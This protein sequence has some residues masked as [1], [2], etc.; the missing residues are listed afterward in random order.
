MM[1]TMNATHDLRTD[2]SHPSRPTA[3]ELD[4][5][6]TQ[7]VTDRD[8][9]LGQ[10]RHD[11][12]RRVADDQVELFVTA[13]VPG[14]LQKEFMLHTPEFVAVHDIGTS[15]SL[16]LLSSMASAAGGPVQ[17]LSIRR[18]G[19]GVA[20]AVLQFVE[21]ALP[22]G[23]PMRL[24]STDVNADT[25]T[26]TQVARVLL[27]FSRLG[28]IL[29]GELPPHALKSQLAPL[30]E[31]LAKDNWPNRDL[32]L[33]PLGS[34]TAMAAQGAQLAGNS[35][36]AVHVTPHA[37]RPKQVWTY[38]SGAWNRLHGK[39]G[40]E[41]A[42]QTDLAQAL[43]RAV[44]PA[45]EADTQPTPLDALGPPGRTS[46][47]AMAAAAAIAPAVALRRAPLPMPTPMSSGARWQS[48]VDRC[49]V[50]KG[51]LVCCVFDL[52]SAK[53]LAH[54]GHGPAPARLAQQGAVLVNGAVEAA[55][56]LGLGS[57]GPETSVTVGAHH[58]LIRPVP[59]HPGIAVLLMLAAATGNLALARV[60][61]ERVEPPQ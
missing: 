3:D 6:R 50:V 32:L 48:Y 9:Y 24:Y 44:V 51:S 36:V 31:A 5:P 8:A 27:A 30:H 60:Q 22:D 11:V 61:I 33:V 57:N 17:R 34:G 45:S 1:P 23:S 49:M 18:Q 53:P 21:V 41:R 28:V 26:R 20:L 12:G 39:P 47:V 58:L 43:P 56:A 13:D 10:G 46:P 35:G 29:V 15:A 55:R 19:H 16:R 7:I 4:S 54:C 52:H 37:E 42:L 25:A 59:G 38:I 14:S 40:G 2:V